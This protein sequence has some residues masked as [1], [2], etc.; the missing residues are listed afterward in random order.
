MF[1]RQQHGEKVWKTFMSIE[2]PQQYREKVR[3]DL[4]CA[5]RFFCL[6]QDVQDVQDVQ[7][8]QDGHQVR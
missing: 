5:A 4:I 3:E 2:P 6:N 8:G 7:D 1:K